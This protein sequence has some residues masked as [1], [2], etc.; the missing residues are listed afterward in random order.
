VRLTP[1]FLPRIVSFF[2]SASI[3]LWRT[4]R[5]VATK[6]AGARQSLGQ[7]L[8]GVG[9]VRVS[10]CLVEPV[11]LVPYRAR[12]G[13]DHSGGIIPAAPADLRS[14]AAVC[15]EGD[16]LGD[17]TAAET[18]ATATTG[19]GEG[20]CNN[21]LRAGSSGGTPRGEEVPPPCAGLRSRAAGH[22]EAIHTGTPPDSARRSCTHT[23]SFSGLRRSQRS[24]LCVDGC[25][26]W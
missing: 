9:V 22:T 7:L 12:R 16:E 6:A 14:L 5:A 4:R 8:G 3:S 24:R 20:A 26:G 1:G 17:E 25:V 21:A 18:V 11:L 23:H 19:A 10:A 2:Q 13:M 15:E